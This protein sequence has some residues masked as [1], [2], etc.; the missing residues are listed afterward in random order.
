MYLFHIPQCNIRNRNVHI[1]VLNDA[2]MGYGTCA[3]W[4]LWNWPIMISRISLCSNL[5]C[6]H[7]PSD[8]GYLWRSK[9]TYVYFTFPQNW[10]RTG[11]YILPREVIDLPV[12]ILKKALLV[13]WMPTNRAKASAI[14]TLNAFINAAYIW[15]LIKRCSKYVNKGVN[16]ITLLV[17][18]RMWRVAFQIVYFIQV[19]V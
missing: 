6:K 19:Y 3:L 9:I 10:N 4:D 8:N 14:S 18:L 11:R 15:V 7:N 2:L 12:S 1:S 5:T 16:W 17:L 13:G